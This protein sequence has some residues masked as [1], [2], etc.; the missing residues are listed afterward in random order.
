MS[1]KPP[2]LA[3]FFLPFGGKLRSDNRWVI[4]AALV[5]WELAESFY[6]EHFSSSGKGAPALP[7]RVALGALLIKEHLSVSDEEAV[8]HI[9]EN[10]YLQY[11]LDFSGFQDTLP[12]SPSMYVHFR[13]RFTLEQLGKINEAIVFAGRPV[14]EKE[15]KEEEEE[16]RG[17]Q[18]YGGPQK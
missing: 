4:L 15:E 3:D 1:P 17:N 16:D 2:Y 5:P 18:K 9:R 10:P 12:F 6:S 7:A 13:K 11:F 8:E 14:E